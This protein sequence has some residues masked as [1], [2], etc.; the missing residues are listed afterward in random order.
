MSFLMGYYLGIFDVNFISYEK[1]LAGFGSV[2]ISLVEPMLY[3]VK[4]LFIGN[5]IDNNDRLSG[6][7]ISLGNISES[8]LTSRIPNLNIDNFLI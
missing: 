2:T 4:T 1:F 7:I 8:L 6:S 5:I 3:V